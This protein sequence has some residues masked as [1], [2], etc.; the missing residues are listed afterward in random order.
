MIHIMT[1]KLGVGV[2]ESQFECLTAL[3]EVNGMSLADG[4]LTVR[5]E[6]LRGCAEMC[7]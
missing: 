3:I 1:N 7:I 6:D 5:A 4:W 2:R